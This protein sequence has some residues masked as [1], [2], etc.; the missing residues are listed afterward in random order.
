MTVQ[1]L[2][3]EHIPEDDE[4]DDLLSDEIQGGKPG[5]SRKDHSQEIVLVRCTIIPQHA[6]LGKVPV[7]NMEIL[8]ESHKDSKEYEEEEKGDLKL[9]QEGKKQT[10]DGQV[11]GVTQKQMLP[12][13]RQ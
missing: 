12:Q 9:V 7:D 6:A 11:K 1:G 8:K 2:S 4:D 10:S 5:Q 3:G 13:T